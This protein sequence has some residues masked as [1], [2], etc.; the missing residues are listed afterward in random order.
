MGVIT[1][2]EL[3]GLGWRIVP[4]RSD[5]ESFLDWWYA[6]RASARERERV[7][8]ALPRI[9][10]AREE[11]LR[12]QRELEA[13]RRRDAEVI[14]RGQEVLRRSQARVAAVRARRAR[15]AERTGHAA[16]VRR[17]YTTSLIPP[18]SISLDLRPVESVIPHLGFPSLLP[19]RRPRT[20]VGPTPPQVQA[21]QRALAQPGASTAALLAPFFA[22]PRVAGQP[23]LFTLTSLSPVATR[24][25]PPPTMTMHG[26]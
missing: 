14:A 17:M 20:T 12:W 22:A 1:M 9:R 10:Q 24:S 7:T 11:R 2:S 16:R 19:P 3:S 8:A 15:L 21:Q 13:R 23:G 5:V 25:A 26:L 4:N 18:G 6:D